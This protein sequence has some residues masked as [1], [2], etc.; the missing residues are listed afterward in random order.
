MS[1]IRIFPLKNNQILYLDWLINR[2]FYL[3][4]REQTTKDMNTDIMYHAFGVSKQECLGIR[5][6][7]NQIIVIL[8]NKMITHEEIS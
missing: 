5:H 6:K 1:V 3:N 4:L 8:P 2:D 7:D